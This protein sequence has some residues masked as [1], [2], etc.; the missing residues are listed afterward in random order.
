ML[1]GDRDVV[2]Y[3]LLGSTGCIDVVSFFA[4]TRGRPSTS[5]P[6]ATPYVLNSS[7][8]HR[9]DQMLTTQQLT[10]RYRRQSQHTDA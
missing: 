7:G 3:V 5:S 9:S 10:R 8:H 6:S 2:F 4:Y 1:C